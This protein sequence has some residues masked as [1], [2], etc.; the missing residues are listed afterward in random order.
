MT[1]REFFGSSIG[2]VAASASAQ[3]PQEGARQFPNVPGLTKYVSEFIAN[4]KY[5]DIPEDVLALGRKSILDGFGLALAGSVSPMGP[6]IRQYVEKF[7]AP[8][9]KSSIVGTG[10]KV[11][12]RFAALANGVAI[13]ADDY[14]DT[15]LA[16]APDRVYGLLTHPTAPVLPAVLALAER[17]GRSGR[18]LLTAYQIGVE[19]E[20]K[21]AEAMQPRHYQDGFHTTGTV[22]TIGAAAGA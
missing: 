7:V 21:I 6:L 16:V 19:V 15:Q 11:P 2:M 8:G 3:P 10:M 22:G 12:T 5:R 1:R 17:D 4:T 14:D 20:C 13:H 9:S 18:D